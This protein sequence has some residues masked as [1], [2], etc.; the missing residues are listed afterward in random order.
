VWWTSHPYPKTLPALTG[1]VAGPRASAL[2]GKTP[3]ETASAACA[4][5]AKIF[6]LDEHLVR[7]NLVATCSHDWAADPFTQGA[8]PEADTLFF[9]DE[10]TD[11]TCNLRAVHA[12]VRSGLRVVTQILKERPTT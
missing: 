1:W 12:A 3:D 2:E 8:Q 10:L 11:I 9:A 5:L 6:A 7:S 4:A